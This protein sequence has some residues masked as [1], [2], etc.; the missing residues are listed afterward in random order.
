MT[1][2]KIFDRHIRPGDPVRWNG[3]HYLAK[4]II[5]TRCVLTIDE[6]SMLN[7]PLRSVR[8]L[9]LPLLAMWLMNGIDRLNN[10]PEV[11]YFLSNGNRN[12]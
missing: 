3:K 5:D 6:E 7:V 1:I 8:K 10:H 11:K 2:K 4:E 9:R 12:N